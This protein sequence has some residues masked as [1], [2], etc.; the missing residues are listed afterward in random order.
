MGVR[1]GLPGVR[2]SSR[3]AGLRRNVG[4]RP[5][6]EGV[7]ARLG[8]G[9]GASPKERRAMG[10]SLLHDG[11]AG[12]LVYLTRGLVGGARYGTKIFANVFAR[13]GG[14]T[15]VWRRGMPV[16]DEI[17]LVVDGTG[18]DLD[19]RAAL[20]R[21]LQNELSGLDLVDEVRQVNA[22]TLPPG[23]KAGEAI[24]F[25]ALAVSLAPEIAS[26]LVE[27]LV[28]WLRRQRTDIK[29]QIDGQLLEGPVNREQRDAIVAAYLERVTSKGTR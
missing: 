12:R 23:A 28:G 15:L 29:I 25:G 22:G 27:F 19:E 5:D 6:R 4:G 26:H 2:R 21:R 10:Q 18:L 7:E 3:A 11:R 1:D 8:R 9:V 16:S 13:I 24:A 17:I 14:V 20:A